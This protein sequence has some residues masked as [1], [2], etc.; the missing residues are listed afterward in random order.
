MIQKRITTHFTLK[1]Y[2]RLKS[3]K[4]ITE[5]FNGGRS[6][7]AHPVKA[8]YKFTAGTAVLQAGFTV[9]SKNFKKAVDR[10]TLKRL[11]RESYRLQKNGLH[12]T[13]ASKGKNAII[14]FIYTGKELAD[15]ETVS[16]KVSEILNTV[17]NDMPAQ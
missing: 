9:S 12:D 8:L 11:L 17:A 13:L 15:L 2:E 6:V 7:N 5:L 16:S 1:K 14:F 10:N 3:R 4:L